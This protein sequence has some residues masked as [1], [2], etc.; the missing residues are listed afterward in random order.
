MVAIAL[1]TPAAQPHWAMDMDMHQ[2]GNN[3]IKLVWFHYYYLTP[4]HNLFPFSLMIIDD[5]TLN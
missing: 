4:F 2:I 3:L 1:Q 5:M